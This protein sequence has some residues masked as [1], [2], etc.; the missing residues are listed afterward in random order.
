[1]SEEETNGFI[2]GRIKFFDP[3]KG[4]GFIRPEDGSRDV[5]LSINVLP[6]D[7]H[8]K[9]DQKCQYVLAEGKKGPYAKDFA[10]L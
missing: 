8:P 4:F 10:V 7:C 2:V 5:F 6:K 9:A 3:R 1:M